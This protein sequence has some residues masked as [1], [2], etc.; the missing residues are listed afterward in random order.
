MAL[1]WLNY[2]AAAIALEAAAIAAL[3]LAMV[4]IAGTARGLRQAKDV[5]RRI[6]AGDFEARVLSIPQHDSAAEL[7]HA[8]NDMIDGCDA[9]VREATAA[10]DAVHHNK[11]YRRI[12]PAGLHGALLQGANTI[13]NATSS[14]EARIRQFER[15]TADLE[16]S[17]S[18]IVVALDNGAAEMS[19]TAGNLRGGA[20]TTRERITSISLSTLAASGFRS[21]GAS[22]FAP[23]L[24]WRGS[25]CTVA[26]AS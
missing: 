6:A 2:P 15:Q 24:L 16:G 10:M 22:L 20:S 23:I 21:A 17:V 3:G 26:V 13:N 12:V 9:F 14:I 4:W 5:C 18:A 11:F 8:V 19:G 7:L 25:T 1:L